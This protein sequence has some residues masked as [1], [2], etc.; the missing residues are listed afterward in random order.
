M[1]A[2]ACIH[3]ITP[4]TC[5]GGSF[6]IGSGYRKSMAYRKGFVCDAEAMKC[7]SCGVHQRMSKWLLRWQWNERIHAQLTE[8]YR[9]NEWIKDSINPGVSGSMKQEISIYHITNYQQINESVNHRINEPMK[10]WFNNAMNQWNSE[11][12]IQWINGSVV[13]RFNES[14][15]Q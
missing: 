6:E 3:Q 13:Q 7:W 15:N 4:G 5:R 8:W 10:Q 14:M 1:H 12:T 9:V 2:I 11:S